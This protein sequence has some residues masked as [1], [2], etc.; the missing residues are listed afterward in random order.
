[1]NNNS[2]Q[3]ARARAAQRCEE[4]FGRPAPWESEHVRVHDLKHYA[5]FRIMPISA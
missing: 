2:W 1:M 5:E 3:A 4:R